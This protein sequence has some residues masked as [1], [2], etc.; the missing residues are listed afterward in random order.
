[1]LTAIETALNIKNEKRNAINWKI[2]GEV[3]KYLAEQVSAVRRICAEVG[4]V[5]TEDIARSFQQRIEGGEESKSLETE[6]ASL[7]RALQVESKQLQ[8]FY[9]PSA[10]AGLYNKDELFG[11]EVAARFP[12]TSHDVSEAG[13]CLALRR[14]TACVF[15]LMRVMEIALKSLAKTLEHKSEFSPSWESILRPLISER[16]KEFTKKSH[17]WRENDAFLSQTTTYLEGVKRSWRNPTM[18]VERE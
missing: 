4:F 12:A 10:K 14:A 16:D 2:D 18:H 6:C 1:M 8:F 7:M 3:R 11:A 15:H 17:I 13:N 5:V 9:L